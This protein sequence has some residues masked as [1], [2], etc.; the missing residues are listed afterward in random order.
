MSAYY[1]ENDRHAA[2]WLRALMSEG[3]IAEGVVDE[4]SIKDV[5][6]NDLRG[7][8][9]CHFFAGIG[10]WSRALRLA[11]WPDDRPVWTGSCPCQSFSNLGKQLG[12][13]D[14]RHLWPEMF[15][16]IAERRPA[17]FFGEQVADAIR[18]G[19][20]DLVAGDLERA[21]Y[22]VG[23]AVFPAAAVGAPHQRDRLYFVA[24][25]HGFRHAPHGAEQGTGASGAC[26]VPDFW[27]DAEW[28]PCPDGKRRAV[29]PGVRPLV[30]GFPAGLGALRGA[31][32]AIV[33]Q[34]AAEFIAAYMEVA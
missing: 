9:Q 25:S 21:D 22:A 12:F 28:V 32:N 33:P 26:L 23:A 30:D 24:D 18:F 5:P 11:G 27:S 2:A 29:K 1:N 31:G 7:F 3:L 4:R 10:G 13:S 8:D 17:A 15:R 14:P 6:P 16:L 19:W 34:Q 20:L